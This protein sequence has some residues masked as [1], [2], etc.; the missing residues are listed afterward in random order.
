MCFILSTQHLRKVFRLI[1]SNICEKY[2]FKFHMVEELVKNPGGTQI[3]YSN[4][5]LL[6]GL[7]CPCIQLYTMPLLRYLA[8]GGYQPNCKFLEHTLLARSTLTLVLDCWKWQ[9]RKVILLRMVQ[10]KR[11]DSGT[12]SHF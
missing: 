5:L 6:D 7:R 2:Q 12:Y 3:S 10:L 8:A 4:G 1:S 9:P 11:C